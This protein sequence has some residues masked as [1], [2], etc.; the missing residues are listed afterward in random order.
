MAHTWQWNVQ[1][2][3]GIVAVMLS[4]GASIATTAVHWGTVNEKV[5]Q[6]EGHQTAQDTKI[7]AITQSAADQ[8]AHDARVEQKLDDIAATV[9]RIEKHK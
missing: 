9:D 6:I 4:T 5:A 7:D 8:K 3:V 1:T 2:V